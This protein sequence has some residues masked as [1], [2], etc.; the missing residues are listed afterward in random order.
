VAVTT[1]AQ[2]LA[3]L[4]GPA[5]AG[6]IIGRFSLGPAY[7]LHMI[8]IVVG[9]LA[10]PLMKPRYGSSPAADFS[11]G[12]VKE[13]IVYLRDHPVLVSAMALD[14]FAVIFGGAASLLPIYASDILNVGPEGFGLLNSAQAAG[15]TL[16]SIALTLLP[17]IANAGRALILTVFAFGV[18]TIAFGLSTL[19]PLSLFLFALRGAADQI[20]F[21]MRQTIVQLGAPD[22]LRGRV[23]SVNQVFIQASNQL[24]GVQSGLTA[25][26]TNAVFAV[27]AGGIGCLIS[28]GVIS[29]LVPDLWRYRI[30]LESQDAET[31]GRGKG[32]G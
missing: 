5:V 13:G 22:A 20:S 14:M 30:H 6:G 4:L 18:L 17:P 28:L 23:I 11:V 21:V 7:G 32:T 10:L 9:L 12:A 16:M 19:F 3:F 25:N 27:V 31:A 29:R 1:T 26:W 24:G 2:Q 15:A 8:L